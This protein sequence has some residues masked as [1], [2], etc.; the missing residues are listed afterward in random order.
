MSEAII[1]V[2]MYTVFAACTGYFWYTGYSDSN[3][4]KIVVRFID[5]IFNVVC[6]FAALGLAIL[7]L[8][9]VVTVFHTT[10]L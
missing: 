10:V 5:G 7:G 2:L 8:I 9:V 6:E 4:D 1:S 3:S